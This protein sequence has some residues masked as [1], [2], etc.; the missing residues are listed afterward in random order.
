MAEADRGR[1]PGSARH[2][3]LAG[4]PG[5]LIL[6]VRRQEQRRMHEPFNMRPDDYR[7]CLRTNEAY[8]WQTGTTPDGSQVLRCKENWLLFDKG[9]VLLRVSGDG[10]PFQDGPILVRRFWL[11]D[12]WMGIEDLE[13]ELALFYTNPDEFVMEEK[14]IEWWIR[15]G[16]FVFHCGW[17]EYVLGAEGQ[18]KIS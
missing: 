7:Y 9:G 8:G 16:Q 1:H 5:Q 12:R 2:E 10:V 17:T 4:G 6:I 18:V 11:P 13:S 15:V 14:D 3:G